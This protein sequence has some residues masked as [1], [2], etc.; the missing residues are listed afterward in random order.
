MVMEKSHTETFENFE[1]Y[2]NSSS[3]GAAYRKLLNSHLSIYNVLTN[4]ELD[5]SI[6]ASKLEQNSM[7]FNDECFSLSSWQTLSNESF[8]DC[9]NIHEERPNSVLSSASED[10]QRPPKR[11]DAYSASADA[12]VFRK[13]G[14]DIKEF[15]TE[16]KD[17]ES[18]LDEKSVLSEFNSFIMPRLSVIGE[19]KSQSI[20]SPFV[21]SV[22]SSSE[23]IP[24]EDILKVFN[25]IKNEHQETNII[26]NCFFVESEDDLALRNGILESQ[27]IFVINDGSDALLDFFVN[28]AVYVFD[29]GKASKL[30]VINMINLKYFITLFHIIRVLR[31]YN[32]WKTPSIRNSKCIKLLRN[33]LLEEISPTEAVEAYG[34]TVYD[35]K[36]CSSLKKENYKT[37]MKSFKEELKA[38]S[39]F[40]YVDPLQITSNFPSIRLFSIIIRKF[41]ASNSHLSI[42]NFI[43]EHFRAL[44]ATTI[45]IGL[46][47]G[48]VQLTRAIQV[49]L[50]RDQDLL[51]A[52]LPPSK[53]MLV[54]HVEEA[55]GGV[56]KS[57]MATLFDSYD[58]Y[59]DSVKNSKIYQNLIYWL[60]KNS[61]ELKCFCHWF[62]NCAKNGIDVI[63]TSLYI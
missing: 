33:Y 13:E 62:I 5:K 26:V 11:G 39:S 40:E 7:M 50:S 41:A 30:T 1:E 20:N 2:D 56:R 12:M 32:I 8:G 23:S 44:Y 6:N 46:G 53:N 49:Y 38:N 21:L 60:S 17:K 36:S 55:F 3:A 34:L 24:R 9:K 22:L 61:R 35:E 10:E 31:P 14:E 43:C 37:M 15:D 29:T 16:K 4:P 25:D 52:E 48:V 18:S 63:S 57:M 28:R 42:S 27:L 47:V 45:T 58:F 19:L 59:A 51:V 54:S